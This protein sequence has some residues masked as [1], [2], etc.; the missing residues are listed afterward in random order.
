MAVQHH[1]AH[2]TACLAEYGER[3]PVLGIAWDGTGY[4]DDGTVWGGEFLLV[5]GARS[6]RIG[7][8]WPFPLLG[9][10]RAAREPR[11]SAAGVCFEAREPLLPDLFSENENALLDAGLRGSTSTRSSTSAGRLFDAWGV[12]LGLPARITYEGEAAIRLED[13]AD[14]RATEEFAVKIIEGSGPFYRLDWRP[15]VAETRWLLERGT[16]RSNVA[17]RFHNAL[18][19]GC[20]E[21][22]HAVGRETVVLSGGC[23]LNRLLSE[24]VESL[25]AGAG[26]RVLTHRHISPGDGGL[27]V[28]QLWAAAFED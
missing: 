13:M 8:L 28:G 15:W 20:L 24:R 16:A 1:H 26:F 21:V 3:G 2:I 25:L 6:Q 17:A 19:R 10:D 5:D 22:A 12:F 14:P 23:F 18:A 7:S 27:A 11:R 9:G 4:G